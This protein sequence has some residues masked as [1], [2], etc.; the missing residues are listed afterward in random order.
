MVIIS[1]SVFNDNILWFGVCTPK[2]F[3]TDC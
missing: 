2:L 3:L 1:L